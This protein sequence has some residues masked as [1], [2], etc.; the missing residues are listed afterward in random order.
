MDA[1]EIDRMSALSPFELKDALIA[2]ASSRGERIMLN[3][4]RG[5]P[6]F[7]ATVPRHGFLQL[8]LFA[9]EEA[10]RSSAGMPEG[11]GGMP[12]PRGIAARFDSFARARDAP[13]IS[14]LVAALSYGRDRLGFDAD[15]FVHEFAEG[16]LGC[17]Y[18]APVRMLAHGEHILRQYLCEE[19]TAGPPPSG[20]IDLFAVEGGTAGITYVFNA[21][22]ENGLLRPGEAIAIGMPIFS[23]YLEIPILGDYQLVEVPIEAD[24]DAGWQYPDHELEKLLDPRIKALLLV[25]P[26]NPTSV[27]LDRQ[28]LDKI[29]DIVT[30]HRQDLIIVTD[31]VYA[32]FA[33]DFVSLF[34]SCPRNTILLYSFSK[35]FGTTGW[36]LGVIAL[37]EDNVLDTRIAALP[38]ADRATLDRRYGSLVIEPRKLKFIDRLVADSRTVALNHTA[39]LSTPQQVQMALFAL[40]ALMDEQGAYKQA[41]R[42]MIRRR[43]EALYRELGLAAPPDPNGVYYYTLLDLERLG[44]QRY[45]RDFVDW[46]LRTKNPLEILFRLAREGGV[47]LLPG[48]GFGTPHPSARVSLANLNEADYAMIGRIIEAIMREYAEEY[49]AVKA[50][51]SRPPPPRRTQS[52]SADAP[53]STG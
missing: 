24:P 32:T 42:R 13:G 16:V 35:Y 18:P 28:G 6:N 52:S 38:P 47:V 5:N 46:L 17:T 49:R 33:D 44:A 50:G 19:M 21:L 29:S 43:H 23:P 31:D 15:A 25:N 27:K 4:G 1:A 39:G 8:G 20:A 10:E 30:R 48:K 7:L 53:G 2:L 14:F 11:V 12:E 40:Y 26:G 3:A 45:G 51:S 41:V 22:R 37:H 36:R 9:M 34:S